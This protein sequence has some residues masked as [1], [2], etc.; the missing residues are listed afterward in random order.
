[1]ANEIIVKI[2]QNL[3]SLVSL[4]QAKNEKI[5]TIVAKA[6]NVEDRVINDEKYDII[7]NNSF[8]LRDQVAE[9]REKLGGLAVDISTKIQTCNEYLNKIDEYLD[10]TTITI[11]RN[12]TSTL[13]NLTRNAVKNS[14]KEEDILE[15]YK[16][17]VTNNYNGGKSK[18]KQTKR[19]Q[20]RKQQTKRKRRR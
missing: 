15:P 14:M 7:M 9:F 5:H 4:F 2:N 18:R 13:E 8:R 16:S 11:N 17:V 10:E 3:D 20:T 6:H 1:M 19:K 12:K